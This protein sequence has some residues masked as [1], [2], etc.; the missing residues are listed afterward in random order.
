MGK[1]G[2]KGFQPTP[3]QRAKVSE[4]TG[5]GVPQ[6]AIAMHLGIGETALKKHFRDELNA[7]VPEANA[8]VAGALFA[9]A[10]NGDTT[11]Q[12]FWLKTRGG[13]KEKQQVEIGGDL[14]L[15]VEFVKPKNANP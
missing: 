15:K 5:F 12:I 13:W 1:R 3:E 6:K 9:K 2:P 4:W 11:A 10:I 7:G 14:N 8:K